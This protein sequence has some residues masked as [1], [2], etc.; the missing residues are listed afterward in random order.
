[1]ML[2]GLSPADIQAIA[3]GVP[4]LTAALNSVGAGGSLADAVNAAGAGLQLDSQQQAFLTLNQQLFAQ[5]AAPITWTQFQA[6]ITNPAAAALM[7]NQGMLPGTADNT[8]LF[9][10][11]GLLAL[12]LLTRK[13]KS[14]S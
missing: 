6:G 9:L 14:A 8:M 11:V 13:K 4:A 2:R 3:T 10:G 12:F 1:M 7:T 5:G